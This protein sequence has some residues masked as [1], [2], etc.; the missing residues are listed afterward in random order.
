VEARGRSSWLSCHHHCKEV[1]FASMFDESVEQLALRSNT[2][3][4]HVLHV[5]PLNPPVI[6]EA[7]P[8]VMQRTQRSPDLFV[9]D[10]AISLD[11]KRPKDCCVHLKPNSFYLVESNLDLIVRQ[12]MEARGS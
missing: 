3:V 6:K 11:P 5:R 1:V 12:Q 2:S 7:I 8:N 4:H 10:H 9:E